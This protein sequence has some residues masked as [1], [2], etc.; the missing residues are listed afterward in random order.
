MH[1]TILIEESTYAHQNVALSVRNDLAREDSVADVV[2]DSLLVT[3]KRFSRWARQNR[4][5]L[6]TLVL[7]SRQ[8]A[9]E[10][11]L[12]DQS[13][14]HASIEGSF[15]GPLA[16]TLLTSGIQNNVN[17]EAVSVLVLLVEDVTSNLGKIMRINSRKKQ[18]SL[19]Y[20]SKKFENC[21][22]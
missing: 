5:G 9:G 20:A 21:S 10:Y 16:G 4:G 22:N 3:S 12:T 14:G 8:A 17:N 13:N 7:L 2:D 6:N 11:S 1:A 19:N 15:D 18:R